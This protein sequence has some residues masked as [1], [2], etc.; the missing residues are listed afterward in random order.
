MG[1]WVTNHPQSENLFSSNKPLIAY[2]K[3]NPYCSVVILNAVKDLPPQAV[4]CP[5][6][7]IRTLWVIRYP[8]Q[9]FGRISLAYGLQPDLG[10][11]A[12][13]PLKSSTLAR[14]PGAPNL[15]MTTK[16]HGFTHALRKG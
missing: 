5:P 4:M 1:I 9:R 3:K 10:A 13:F 6:E 14:F 16:T 15:R 11:A 7:E 2:V 12:R 8:N